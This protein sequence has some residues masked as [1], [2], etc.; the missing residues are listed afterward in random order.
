M[1]QVDDKVLPQDTLGV[2]VQTPDDNICE[3]VVDKTKVGQV[4]AGRVMGEG[5]DPLDIPSRNH[6]VSLGNL[7]E[8]NG[9]GRERGPP[10]VTRKFGVAEEESSVGHV[11][12]GRGA[13]RDTTIDKEGIRERRFGIGSEEA[14]MPKVELGIGCDRLLNAVIAEL[15]SDGHVIQPSPVSLAEVSELKQLFH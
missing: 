13:I 10:K 3:V 1:P 12:P 5:I 7:V 11:Q 14:K 9:T 8:A 4:P 6:G 2:G 15:G